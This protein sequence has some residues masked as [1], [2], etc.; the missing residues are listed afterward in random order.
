MSP[1]NAEWTEK[2]PRRLADQTVVKNVLHDNGEWWRSV[3]DKNMIRK[4]RVAMVEHLKSL[5]ESGQEVI[6]KVAQGQEKKRGLVLTA[7]NTVS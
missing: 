2:C 5:V 3:V 7:G 4:K 6:G 1:E